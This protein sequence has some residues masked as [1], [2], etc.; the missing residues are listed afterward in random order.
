MIFFE[1]KLSA[2]TTSGTVY[3]LTRW[4]CSAC[5][6]FGVYLLSMQDATRH[7]SAHAATHVEVQP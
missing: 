3:Q 2:P 6:R 4:R 5:G 7:A 1:H